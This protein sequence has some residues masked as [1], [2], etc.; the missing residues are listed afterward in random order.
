MKAK[1][2]NLQKFVGLLLIAAVVPTILLH[3]QTNY[4][5]KPIKQYFTF[6]KNGKNI[7]YLNDSIKSSFDKINDKCF[8][9][10][11][12]FKGVF[13]CETICVSNKCISKRHG[14]NP[15]IKEQ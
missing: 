6:Y 7:L 5:I 9:L 13:K 15:S 14:A 1:E 4:L 11:L 12:Y 8:V 3:A 2:R 10:K